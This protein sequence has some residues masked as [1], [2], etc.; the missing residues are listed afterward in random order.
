MTETDDELRQALIGEQMR[1]VDKQMRKVGD[2]ITEALAIAESRSSPG[3]QPG[4]KCTYHGIVDCRNCREMGPDR[5][6]Q[7][8]DAP[9]VEL[10]NMR[11]DGNSI[12][13]NIDVVMPTE[14]SD[15]WH[16]ENAESVVEK[17]LA[18]I[19]SGSLGDITRAIVILAEVQEDGTVTPHVEVATKNSLETLGMLAAALDDVQSFPTIK[20]DRG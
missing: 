18:D 4:A 14:E 10:T 15:V 11:M 12:R 9:T 7:A 13:G 17:A 5:W 6:N 16:A 2:G 1:K 8:E 19:R 3:W 20:P